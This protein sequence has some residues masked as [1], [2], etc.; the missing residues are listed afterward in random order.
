MDYLPS[1]AF[2]N[3]P[4]DEYAQLEAFDRHSVMDLATTGTS[5]QTALQAALEAEMQKPE[6]KPVAAEP[7]EIGGFKTDA[8]A[9]EKVDAKKKEA[10]VEKKKEPKAPAAVVPEVVTPAAKKAVKEEEIKQKTTCAKEQSKDGLYTEMKSAMNAE[11]QK[12]MDDAA[13]KDKQ[14][15]QLN[16]RH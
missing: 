4:I 10:V 15:N 11:I 7:V 14:I 13:A 12:M 9:E 6:N 2:G 5:A 1:F 3:M 16:A 8:G